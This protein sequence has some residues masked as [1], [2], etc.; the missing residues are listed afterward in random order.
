MKPA[1]PLLFAAAAALPLPAAAKDAEA[2]LRDKLT[3]QR[4]NREAAARYAAR[5]A[6]FRREAEES[7][8]R[9]A[10]YARARA[11]YERDLA[12]WRNGTAAQTPASD[13]ARARARYQR[14]MADWRRQAADCT[15]GDWSACD[16]GR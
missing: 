3:I 6:G 4:L 9:I 15:A 16:D 11:Q 1:L 13:Y 5:D 7:D 2:L 12:D 14:D 8:A 10:D